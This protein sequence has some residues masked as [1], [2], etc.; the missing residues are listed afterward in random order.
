MVGIILNSSSSR[1]MLPCVQQVV[2][3]LQQV[4]VELHQVVE[5]QKEEEAMVEDGGSDGDFSDFQIS[6][7]LE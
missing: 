6:F 5:V 3:E 4:V 1:R 7:N 2:V